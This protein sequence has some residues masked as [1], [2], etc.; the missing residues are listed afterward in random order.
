VSFEKQ[1]SKVIICY[2]LKRTLVMLVL[3][4]EQSLVVEVLGA[5]Q[6]K[7]A[8]EMTHTVECSGPIL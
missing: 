1:Q 8:C 2:V 3:T 5:R 6:T 4:V 7:P